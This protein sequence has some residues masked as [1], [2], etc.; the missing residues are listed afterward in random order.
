MR[1]YERQAWRAIA[2]QLK[3]SRERNKPTIC[4]HCIT[5]VPAYKVFD[6]L[7]IPCHGEQMRRALAAR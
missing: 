4:K 3:A 2:E 5:V 1:K 7:C 6:D